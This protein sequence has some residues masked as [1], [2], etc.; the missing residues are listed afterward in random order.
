MQ[1]DKEP[2]VHWQLEPT[3]PQ[4]VRPVLS[5]SVGNQACVTELL[6]QASIFFSSMWAIRGIGRG[7]SSAR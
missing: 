2:T 7:T 4:A 5:L 1:E 3:I 6:L